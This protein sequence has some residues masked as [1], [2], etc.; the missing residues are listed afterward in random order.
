MNCVKRGLLKVCDNTVIFLVLL[1]TLVLA[2][3]VQE[4]V[5]FC[6]AIEESVIRAG[7]TDSVSVECDLQSKPTAANISS[8]LLI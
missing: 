3:P 7:L 5:D 2:A 6:A 8:Y 1:L 4:H